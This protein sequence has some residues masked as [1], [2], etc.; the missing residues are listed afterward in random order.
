MAGWRAELRARLANGSP[1][2][3]VTLADIKGSAP[4]ELGAKLIVDAQGQWGTIGGGRLEWQMVLYAREL[5]GREAGDVLEIKEF[6]LGKRLGQCCGGVVS[7][8][9]QRLSLAGLNHLLIDPP[10]QLHKRYLLTPLDVGVSSAEWLTAAE[11]SEKGLSQN[12]SISRFVTVGDRQCLLED[13]GD[14]RTPIMV[15][16]AGHVGCALINALAYLPFIPTWVDPRDKTA[17][18]QFSGKHQSQVKAD[19]E[20]EIQM[21]ASGTMFVVMTH[22]HELDFRIVCQILERDDFSWLGLIGSQ[23]KRRRFI[24]QLRAHGFSSTQ[25]DR[26]TCPIGLSGISS[27]QPAAIAASV[28]AQLLMLREAISDK[29]EQPDSGIHYLHLS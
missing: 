9:I 12:E 15:F 4:Q 11:L 17:L 26:M 29:Q 8:V 19:F 7:L 18:V 27:K 16:G 24:H 13:T 3:L 14:Q 6:A 23:T 2:V 28:T 20:H 5:L 22:D 10:V 1:C 21:A 25:M